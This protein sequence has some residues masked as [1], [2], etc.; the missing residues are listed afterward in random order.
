MD[1]VRDL[2]G[3]NRDFDE[4]LRCRR[5]A[6][7]FDALD[8]VRRW[9]AVNDSTGRIVGWTCLGC[10]TAAEHA[11]RSAEIAGWYTDRRAA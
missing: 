9:P 1:D 10:M 3:G 11:I 6:P 5:P 8:G 2:E 4:C 7:D